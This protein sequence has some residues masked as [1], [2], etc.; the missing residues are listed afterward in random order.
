MVLA[1]ELVESEV[2]GDLYGD[3]QE[4]KMKMFRRMKRATQ[5]AGVEY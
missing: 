4:V 2:K 5:V 1:K 3:V